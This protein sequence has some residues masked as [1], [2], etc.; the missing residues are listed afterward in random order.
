MVSLSDKLLTIDR[1]L[2]SL[3]QVLFDIHFPNFRPIVCDTSDRVQCMS[4]VKKQVNGLMIDFVKRWQPARQMYIRQLQH[5]SHCTDM[6]AFH[7]CMN[8][9]SV[10]EEEFRLG[11]VSVSTVNSILQLELFDTSDYKL[12]HFDDVLGSS[13]LPSVWDK[14]SNSMALLRFRKSIIAE[15]THAQQRPGHHGITVVQR[16]M[17]IRSRTFDNEPGEDNIVQVPSAV[18][19][20][21]TSYDCLRD[22][23]LYSAIDA[24]DTNAS[25]SSSFTQ[26]YGC[27]VENPV[28]VDDDTDE[29]KNSTFYT[30]LI[31]RCVLPSTL[32]RAQARRIYPFACRSG[33]V[34]SVVFSEIVTH[35]AKVHACD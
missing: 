9:N 19:T 29:D 26:V 28:A 2:A 24:A 6:S 8:N 22:T 13:E 7:A 18:F 20:L 12:L 34:M 16:D 32:H 23:R 17:R 3:H 4:R 27:S 14:R 35:D 11:K 5:P 15:M 10:L 1:V 21:K 25:L 31:L 33:A 30:D